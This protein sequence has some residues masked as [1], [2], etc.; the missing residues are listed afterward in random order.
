MSA[1]EF[2][3]FLAKKRTDEKD[4]GAEGRVCVLPLRR[5]GGGGGLADGDAASGEVGFDLGD[6]EGAEVE[7]AGGEDGAGAAMVEGID[8]VIEGAGA[9]AG[10]DRDGHGVA[11]GAGEGAIVAGLGA[12]GVHAGEE[13][14]AS[15]EADGFAG[16]G[17]GVEIGGVAAAVGINAPGA[18]VGFAF[19]VDGDDDTLSAEAVGGVGDELRGFD[20]GG[21]EGDLIGSAF[22]HG[23]DVG[24]GAEAA[25]DGEGHEALFG[26]A[27]DD[28]VH[29]AATVGGGG[30]VEEDEFVGALGI[31]GAGAFNG[32]AGIAKF[33]ELH[34]LYDAAGVDVEAGDD[35]SR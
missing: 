19:G 29:D 15:T 9:A 10:D 7:K 34:A 30:D 35:S 6:G 16:P 8:K 14:F 25:A 24:E 2:K 28:V 22:E 32:V 27:G 26:G 17:D 11:D 3:A 1:G 33:E 23:L 5:K 18:A 4:G 12:I 21:V 13:D 20:G 31:V